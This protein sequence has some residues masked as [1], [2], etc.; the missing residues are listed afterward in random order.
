MTRIWLIAIVLASTSVYADHGKQVRFVGVHPIPKT[1]GGGICY[2]EGPHVHIYAAPDKLQYRD[3]NGASYFVGDPVAYG[4]DGP[5]Y[6]YKGPHPIHVEAVVGDG[7]PDE[8]YCYIEGPH[9]HPFQV[10]GPGIKVVGDTTFFVGEPPKA[11]VEAR[12]RFVGINAVY[13]PITYARPTV[14]VD[15]PDGWIGAR[16]DLPAV[17]VDAPAVVVSPPAVVVVPPSIDV[18]IPAPSIHIGVDLGIG[19]GVGVGG[20]HRGKHR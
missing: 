13:R 7:V 3:H 15:A 17:V 12:P 19:V 4:Y 6:A 8:E 20:G 14:T 9:F 11:F 18:R 16:V 5:H 1:E 2:I 10:E